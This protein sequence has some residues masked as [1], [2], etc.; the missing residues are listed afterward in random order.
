MVYLK[1]YTSGGEDCYN[2]VSLV[3][4]FYKCNSKLVSYNANSSRWKTFAVFAD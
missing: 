1:S 4:Y 2:Y 3:S